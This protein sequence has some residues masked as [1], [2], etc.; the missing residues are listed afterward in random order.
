AVRRETR[1]VGQLWLPNRAAKSAKL[2]VVADGHRYLA[3][4]TIEELIRRDA[5]VSISIPL[6]LSPGVEI[7]RGNVRQHE[8]RAVGEADVDPLST[9]SALAHDERRQDRLHCIHAGNQID[10][11]DAK[12]HRLAILLPGNGHKPGL[13]LDDEVVSG[14]FF[15]FVTA[16]IAG[17]GADDQA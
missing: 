4:G 3:V 11:G 8:E 13:G 12:A 17:Y 10:E 7:A 14:P 16:P 5:W 1:I 9:P 6:R 15:Q 2:L